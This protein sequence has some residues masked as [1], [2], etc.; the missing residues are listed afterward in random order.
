MHLIQEIVEIFENYQFTTEI[1]VASVRHNIHIVEAARMGADICTC[2]AAVIEG[3]FKHPLTDIG[4]ERFLKDWEKAQALRSQV[5]CSSTPDDEQTDRSRRPRA[6]RGAGRRRR[7]PAR[8]H[9]AGKLTARERIEL[10]F[11]PGT[12]EEIDKLVTHRCR[13]F[14]M[15]EQIVPGDGVVAGQGGSTA[16]RSTRSRRTSR[17]SAA[18]S[19]R[20][21]PRRSS[22]SWIWR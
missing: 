2:P 21:T 17:C 10:L 3:M 15:D 8:Q 18:R 7:A 4:L 13:D 16:A 5:G 9:E 19:P 22:R 14:G 12:F 1:L 6:P 11:D 20:R